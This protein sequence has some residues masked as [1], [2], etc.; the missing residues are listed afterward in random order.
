M[1]SGRK[2]TMIN[3]AL[4]GVGSWGKNY[5]ATAKKLPDIRIKYLCATNEKSF[6][7]YPGDYIKTTNYQYLFKFSD[8]DGVIIATPNATHDEITYEFLKRGFTVLVEKPLSEDYQNAKKLLSLP[9]K[10][11]GKLQV[12]HVYLFDPAYIKTKE[13]VKN[14][15]KIRYIDYEGTSYGLLRKNTSALWDIGSHAISLCVDISQSYPKAISAWG[16]NLLY[17]KTKFFDTTSLKLEFAD[18]TYAYIRLNW[19]FPEKRRKLV[20]TG[21]SDSIMY[22]AEATKKIIYYKDIVPNQDLYIRYQ[23]AKISYPKYSSKTSLENEIIEFAKAITINRAITYSGLE[24]GL[25]VTQL[26]DLAE[27]SIVQNGKLLTIKE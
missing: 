17:P 6:A 9:K 26:L 18:E 11:K 23:N 22:D 24:L 5:L 14:I 3:L 20:I 8:I 2:L 16:Q 10:S 13:L 21:E 4:I 25:K 15:G 27:Q 12:G 19:I 1:G 7:A